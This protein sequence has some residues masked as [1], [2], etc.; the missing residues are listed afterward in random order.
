LDS[1]DAR[2]FFD[3]DPFV[4]GMGAAALSSRIDRDGGDFEAHGNVGVGAAAAVAGLHAEALDYVTGDLRQFGRLWRGVARMDNDPYLW[5]AGGPGRASARRHHFVCD[6]P[7]SRFEAIRRRSASRTNAWGFN[8]ADDHP[9]NAG[10]KEIAE[11]FQQWF[12]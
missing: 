4:E 2:A 3:I 10:Q 9:M 7:L 8:A 6:G 12:H 1:F 11:I 5:S